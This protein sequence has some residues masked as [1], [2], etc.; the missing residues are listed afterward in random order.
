MLCS[1]THTRTHAHQKCYFILTNTDNIQ[2]LTNHKLT[3]YA[4][5]HN[6]LCE[7]NQHMIIY[8]IATMK[9]LQHRPYRHIINANPKVK[10]GFCTAY[11]C[12]EFN[13]IVRC[14]TKCVH[15]H[16]PG[17]IADLSVSVYTNL[18]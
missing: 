5:C 14:S 7:S 17:G 4:Y 11:F 9:H 1:I 6:S 2:V 18:A 16:T 3:Y 10:Y 15:H 12:C 13:S 8:H